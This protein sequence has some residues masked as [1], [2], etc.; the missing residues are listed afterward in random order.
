[1]LKRYSSI[2]S[3]ENC[4]RLLTDETAENGLQGRGV[5]SALLDVLDH[6][7]QYRGLKK[8]VGGR[9]C[10]AGRVIKQL[11]VENGRPDPTIAD[12]FAQTAGIWVNAM[13]ERPP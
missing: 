8:L 5:Y 10:S 2:I 11:E 6:G 12:C 3:Y 13:T 1:M 7:P 4:K 9:F